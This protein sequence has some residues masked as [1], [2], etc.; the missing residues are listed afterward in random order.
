MIR[1][2][3]ELVELTKL[4]EGSAQSFRVRAYEKA[5]TALTELDRD[6]AGMSEKELSALP[7]I[8]ASSA[9]KIREA[10][11]TG[12]MD[13]LDRLRSEYPAS[14]LELTRIPGV[15]PKTALLLRDELGVI[16]VDGLREAL[17]GQRVRELPG[18]GAKSEE[19]IAQSITRLGMHGKDRRTPIAE[20]LP[21]AIEITA[22]LEAV[23]GVKRV[24]YCG[25][26]RRFRETIGDIDILVASTDPGAVSDAFV[27][28]SIADEV[29]AQG[30][31]KSVILTSGGLQVDLRVVAPSSFGAAVM[32][33]TG[34]KQHNIEM[35]Q[36]AIERGWTLNEYGLSD[37][38]TGDVVASRTEKAIYEAMDL[39]FI[40]PELREGIGEIAD[41]GTGALPRLVAERDLKGDL[42]VHTDWS[43]DGRAPL[44]AMLA[45]A[46]ERNLQYIAITDHAEGLAI[47]GL[48]RERV[49]EQR[50]VIERAR[51]DHPGLEILHGSELNIAPDGSLDWDDEFLAGFDWG[52]ASVHS[53]FDLDAGTQT[54]RIIT[55]MEHPAV[56]AIG[57]LSG[58]MIGRRPGI[59]FDVDAVLEAAERTRCAIEV[60]G[61]LDRLDAADDVLRRARGR[62]V[63]FVL[64]TDAHAVSEYRNARWAVHQARRGWVDKRSI[65]NTWPAKRFLQWVE[66]KRSR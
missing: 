47:N 13:K 60:N 28:L 55:A 18:M 50:A 6:V 40:P 8:G 2:F 24:E 11:E 9:K 20:A 57:H 31:T 3:S 33:F 63:L 15:G 22:A 16:D 66:E 59:E 39:P 62:D 48:S 42:H 52:V 64:D 4:D 46:V 32:Y 56:N 43:G 41:A 37:A 30:D 1:L 49:L 5:V 27:S 25:S 61:H 53:H 23:P 7:G 12:T 65:A 29:V 34:S 51:A 44:D 17:E 21:I 26:L 36:R 19:K 14:L 54:A 38:D 58:R 35:R 45:G 10:V